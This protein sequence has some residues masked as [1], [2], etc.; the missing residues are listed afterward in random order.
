MFRSASAWGCFLWLLAGTALGGLSPAT[1]E[2]RFELVA[3]DHILQV[4][5]ERVTEPQLLTAVYEQA[6][7]RPFWDR[8]QMLRA[9]RAWIERAGDEGL[10]PDDYH[11]TRLAQG[12]LAPLDRE[13]LAT[14]AFLTLALHLAT[15]KADPGRLFPGWNFAPRVSLPLSPARLTAVLAQGEISAY[16]QELLPTGGYA[17]LREA[18]LRYRRLARQGGWPALPPGKS[19]RLGERGERVAILRRRLIVSGDL[20]PGDAGEDS[21]FDEALEAAVRRFQT[22]HFLE[23]D[24][25][26]GRRT[27]QALNVPA[28]RRAAQ[29]RVNLERLRW[30]HYALPRTYL[31]VEVPAFRLRWIEGGRTIWQAAVQVGRPRFPTPIFHDRITYL[32]FNPTW[33]VPRSIAR[34]ELAPRLVQDPAGFLQR[35]HMDLLTPDGQVVDPATVDW[36]AITPRNFPYIL[37]QRPGPDN[38][39]GRVKFMF[40]NR[41]HVYLHDTPSQALF[42]K[43]RRAFSHGCVR[44]AHALELAQALLHANGPGWDRQRIEALL[45][46]G[47]TRP[48]VLERPMPIYLL[49]LTA[50][51][52]A[53]GQ[54]E[55]RPD[56]YRRDGEVLRALGEEAAE[57]AVALSLVEN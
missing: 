31:R 10:N 7:F 48:I 39:L 16:L 52:D 24:G 2:Q 34:R 19:L 9:L 1:I 33:T 32:V 14:D 29:L 57:K 3:G 4:A 6:G 17:A 25:V 13:L 35:H 15:G 44:V 28:G 38:A 45:A 27:R 18:F 49:Y 37:R 46:Q 54:V 21:L 23:A 20:A 36:T 51:V 22:R 30:L 55:F 42:H 11:R 5:S 12:K 8:P 56:L 40:P 26:V 47:E 53:E 41:Y 43:P 50:A